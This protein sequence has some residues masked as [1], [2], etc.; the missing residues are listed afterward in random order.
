MWN[1]L[2]ANIF[3]PLLVVCPSLVSKGKNMLNERKFNL[4]LSGGQYFPKTLALTF[5]SNGHRG[6]FLRGLLV[7]RTGHTF[8]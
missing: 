6:G 2:I 1:S 8:T 4:G 3:F 5:T 7:V